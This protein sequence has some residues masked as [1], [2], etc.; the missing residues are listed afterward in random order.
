[1]SGR[2]NPPHTRGFWG[3]LPVDSASGRRRRYWPRSGFHWVAGLSNCRSSQSP[4]LGRN[5]FIPSRRPRVFQEC[6]RIGARSA[7]PFT[8]P[9]PAG[10]VK[11][12]EEQC[13]PLGCGWIARLPKQRHT[14]PFPACDT[15]FLR[16]PGSGIPELPL[17]KPT[18]KGGPLA[19]NQS[20]GPIS[21]HRPAR[22]RMQIEKTRLG[23]RRVLNG[24]S[25][26]SRRDSLFLPGTLLVAMSFQALAA[27]VLVHLETTLLFQITHGNL[28]EF[29]RQRAALS[30]RC[31]AETKGPRSKT[32]ISDSLGTGARGIGLHRAR[33][34][35]SIRASPIPVQTSPSLSVGGK[36]QTSPVA[37]A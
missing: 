17:R 7:N 3:L 16:A 13:R 26:G 31:K 24:P 30:A 36:T 14:H 32:S 4:N 12:N 10:D 1:M 29:L 11:R 6:H 23:R 15:L 18:V 8:R 35:R 2:R 19:E 20:V 25:K 37:V 27:L 21:P 33:R 34:P 28:P 5:L 9:S 22:H